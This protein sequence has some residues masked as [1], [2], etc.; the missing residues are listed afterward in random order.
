MINILKLIIISILNS[1]IFLSFSIFFREYEALII[2]IIASIFFALIDKLEKN[3]NYT[4]NIN[5]FIINIVCVLCYS[6]LSVFLSRIVFKENEIISFNILLAIVIFLI[7]AYLLYS[8]KVEEWK[9][10]GQH[11]W[12]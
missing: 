4:K 11:Q 10:R 6:V 2:L 5:Y 8:G 12:R 9:I 7:R 3:I 1:F